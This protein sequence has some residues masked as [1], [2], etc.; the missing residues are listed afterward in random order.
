VVNEAERAKNRTKSKIRARVEH[1]IGVIKR[2]FGFKYIAHITGDG[3][4]GCI[5]EFVVVDNWERPPRTA[6]SGSL[7]TGLGLLRSISFA[8]W[9]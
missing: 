5:D 8:R 7:A 2:V 4:V 9:A 1:S 6:R 3:L